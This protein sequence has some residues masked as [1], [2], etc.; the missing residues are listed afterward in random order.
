MC[1]RRGEKLSV[2]SSDLKDVF[3]TLGLPSC[4]RRFFILAPVRAE[5]VGLAHLEGKALSPQ[6]WVFPR[7][8]VMPMGWSHTVNFC[9]HVVRP[10]VMRVPG[11]HQDMFVSDLR[12]FPR[13]D[14]GGIVVYVDNT[15]CLSTDETVCLTLQESVSVELRRVGLCVHE[16]SVGAAWV[17]TLG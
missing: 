5:E 14:E 8:S 6:E 1:V 13:L 11:T 7:L 17:A 4:L 2:S 12:P 15:V 3:Y 10:A 9:Q 16:E